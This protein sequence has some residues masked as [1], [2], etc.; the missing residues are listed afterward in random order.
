MAITS[1]TVGGVEVDPLLSTFDIRETVGGVSTLSCDV[2]SSGSPVQ[3]FAVFA[4]VA[5]EEDGTTI[6]AGTVTQAR[7]RGFGGPNLYTDGAPQIVTTITAED[8]GRLADRV[9]VTETVAEGTTLLDFLTTLVSTYLAA[10]GVSLDPAQVTGATLPAMS[11]E[12]AR[13]SEV[14]QALADATGYLWRIDYEK[15]LRMWLPGDLTAPFHIAEYDE[16]PRWTGDVE[17]ETILGDHYA[18]RVTVIGAPVAEENRIESWVGDGT[19]ATFELDYTLTSHQS[20]VAHGSSYLATTAA[21]KAYGFLG[22]S[23]NF[24]ANSTVTIDAVTYTFESSNS[25]TAYRIP[26][27]STTLISKQRLVRAIMGTGTPGTDYGTGTSAHPTV[28]AYI[29]T[30]LG[31]GANTLNVMVAKY[32]TAGV[33]GNGTPVS[34]TSSGAVWYW[35]GNTKPGY[36]KGGQDAGTYTAYQTVNETLNTAGDTTTADWTYDPPTNSITRNLGAPAAG[37]AITLTFNG[38]TSGPTATAEDAGEIAAHGLYET[39]DRRSDIT[40]TEAAQELADALLAERLNSGEQ[41]LT[42][43]T[44]Y[45]APTLRAG[46]QQTL[47]ATARDVSGAYIIR[48]LRI[49]AEVPATATG[50]LTRTIT[51]KR[52]EVMVG[53]WQHTYR[54]W[55][56]IG[57]GGLVTTSGVAVLAAGA[58]PPLTS[59][60]FNRA[61]AFGGA[62]ALTYDETTSTLMVGTGHTPAGTSNLLVGEGHTVVL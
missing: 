11:F 43:E 2:V 53:K 31:G 41:I 60:Q 48:D 29:P 21:I 4:A 62:P 27:G 40:T 26:I 23:S 57:G 7:E 54:D 25:N 18:N 49:R 24:P 3:R 5:V 17:V 58:A 33:V 38:T 1:F 61:G 44:R 37:D 52:T 13:A 12:S 59:V 32:R 30:N 50:W 14:L 8:H 16:P 42:Y 20:F 6:F 36:L 19:T 51:A 55:L 28:E 9:T 45:T 10:L 56:K 35:E 46:Q 34:D 15:Q 39:V 22:T 47:V